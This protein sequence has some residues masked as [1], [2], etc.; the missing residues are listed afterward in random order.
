[1]VYRLRGIAYVS[2]PMFVRYCIR[3]D[4]SCCE[5]RVIAVAHSISVQ[6]NEEYFLQARTPTPL[7]EPLL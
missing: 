6:G 4:V 2:L 7:Y 1:M 5:Y 3:V